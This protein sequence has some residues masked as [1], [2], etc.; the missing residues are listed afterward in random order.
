MFRMI[1]ICLFLCTGLYAHTSVEECR[2]KIHISELSFQE[3]GMHYVCNG[4]SIPITVLEYGGDGYMATM[5]K[6]VAE[7]ILGIWWC[8]T[9][10]NWNSRFDF[11]CIYCGGKR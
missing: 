7:D 4:A 6:G 8:Y 5:P 2:V 9:C 10:Q 3:D 11:S 1:G